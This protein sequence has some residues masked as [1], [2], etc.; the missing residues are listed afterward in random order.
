[1]PRHTNPQ[2]HARALG[3]KRAQENIRK[4]DTSDALLR[5]EKFE[6]RI[7]RMEADADLVNYGRRTGLTEEFAELETDEE[8]EK[9]LAALKSAPGAGPSVGQNQ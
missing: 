7:E 9:E 3:S 5:F 8:L 6:N 1:M 2:R 4:L